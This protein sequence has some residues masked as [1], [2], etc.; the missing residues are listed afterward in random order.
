MLLG[1]NLEKT[2]LT[3]TSIC[4][5]AVRASGWRRPPIGVRNAQVII[6]IIFAEWQL[7]NVAGYL[8]EERRRLPIITLPHEDNQCSK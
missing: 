1:N 2:Q 5:L 3:F 6:I 8:I 7:F 4:N